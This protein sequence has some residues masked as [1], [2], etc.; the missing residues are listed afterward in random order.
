M[1][2][3][4]VT[5]GLMVMRTLNN[6]S[7]QTRRLLRLQEQL[8]TGRIINAPSDGPLA[9]RRAINLRT[10]IAN[11]EQY[12][13][14]I[15][16]AGRPLL[17]TVTA[18]QTV[19]SDFQRVYELTL[20][21][22]S[23]TY[24]Q[25]QLDSIAAEIDQLLEGVFAQANHQ[26][27]GRFVFSGTRTLSQP[28]VATR[29]ADGHITAVAYEGNDEAIEIAV[30]EGILVAVNEPGSTV[31]HSTQDAF[32]LLINI[33]DNLL[34]G[35][36]TSLQNER[37]TELKTLQDQLLMSIARI[38]ATQNRTERLTNNLYDHIQQLRE[39]LSDNI[40]ADYAETVINLDAQSNAFQAA[41]NAAAR[42]IQPSLLDFMR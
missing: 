29:D 12:L 41:L 35:D 10:A 23:G 24:A 30:A 40:D 11:S 2:T 14:N 1:P 32:E 3:L 37:L 16:S 6:L 7:A 28:F 22:A 36:Q 33:R 15:S 18:I 34:A 27:A 4:R 13:D 19:V 26:T 17:E 9:A 42:V 39:T 31:F 20:Q 25:P 8:A 5:Q 38:G 21:G